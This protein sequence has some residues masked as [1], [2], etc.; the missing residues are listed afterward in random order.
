MTFRL[1]TDSRDD[2]KLKR[3]LNMKVKNENAVW[4]PFKCLIICSL[5]CLFPFQ[6]SAVSAAQVRLG[7]FLPS[8]NDQDLI[9]Y[10]V[11][12][13][14][15]SRNY[16]E[17]VDVGKK[18]SHIITGLEDNKTYYFALK[19][20]FL[21]AHVESEFS[22]EVSINTGTHAQD[23]LVDSGKYK[24]S[25]ANL[26]PVADAGADQYEEPGSFVTLDGSNSSDPDGDVLS[27]LWTQIGGPEVALDN[28]EASDPTFI[29]PE[30]GILGKKLTFRLAVKDSKGRWSY[31]SCCVV[32][33]NY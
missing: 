27:Y 16:S 17:R 14:N 19:S 28:P 26:A 13:G 11:Y 3:D 2:K 33:Q 12:W 25:S 8:G 9:G 31:D 18:S 15:K 22:N 23:L 7:W 6:Q 1:D 29:L 30:E 20:Y 4:M 24:M 21:D 5:L 10:V 32:A